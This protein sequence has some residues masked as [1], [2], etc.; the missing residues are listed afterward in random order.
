MLR[1]QVLTE[2]SS[3]TVAWSAAIRLRLK[4]GEGEIS[5]I[6]SASSTEAVCRVWTTVSLA[7]G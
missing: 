1:G 3:E 7:Y 6:S 2:L 4:L 5:R